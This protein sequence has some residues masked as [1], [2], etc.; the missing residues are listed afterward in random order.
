M[1]TNF[2]KK[3]VSFVLAEDL[4]NRPSSAADPRLARV[5]RR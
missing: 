1:A 2:S 3:K 4:P 5:F